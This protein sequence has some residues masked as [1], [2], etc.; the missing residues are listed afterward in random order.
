MSHKDPL[1]QPLTKENKIKY[2]KFGKPLTKLILISQ[3]IIV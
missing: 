1:A 3:I 2:V